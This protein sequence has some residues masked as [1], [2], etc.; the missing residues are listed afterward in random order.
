MKLRDF[1][2]VS[3]GEISYITTLSA[4][5]TSLEPFYLLT[6]DTN[7]RLNRRAFKEQNTQTFAPPS[8]AVRWLGKGAA[9]VALECA[10][11]CVSSKMVLV[12]QA[13]HFIKNYYW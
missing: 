10:E 3:L 7:S 13:I 6:L 12:N 11:D 1:Y 5:E 8:K 9:D 4:V 2:K